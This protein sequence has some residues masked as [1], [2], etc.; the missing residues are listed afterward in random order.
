MKRVFYSLILVGTIT[1]LSGCGC[2]SGGCGSY[3]TA[4]CG[5]CAC[6]ACGYGFGYNDWY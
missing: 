6:N 2:L 1:L 5:G 4:S 3:Y